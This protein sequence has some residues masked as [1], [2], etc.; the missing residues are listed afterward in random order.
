MRILVTGGTGFVGAHL[1]RFL[2]SQDSQI[3]VLASGNR[4]IPNVPGVQYREADI[5]DAERV[6]SIVREVNPEQIYHL[7]GITAVDLSWAQPRLTYE[8]N[9]FGA[10]NLFEAAM[11][12]PAPPRIL[13]IST[14]QVYASSSGSLS[15][16][17]P[18]RPNNPYAASK[19]MAELLIAQYQDHASGGI[20]TARPFNHTGP[21][22]SP[23]FVLPSMAK[24]FAE[25]E[26]GLR[27]PHL[28]LGNVDVGRDFTDVRDIVRAYGMLLQKGKASE[29]YNV[30][31]GSAVLLSDIIKVFQAVSGTEV[32]IEIDPEKVRPKDAAEICGDPHKLQAATS[33]DREIPLKKTVEDTLNYWRSQCRRRDSI[34]P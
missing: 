33:W 32:T 16:D 19:A 27:P 13:N 22:Q 14:S 31:S 12:L 20:I 34:E 6:R 26:S 11:N 1:I 5:R 30:C 15:E 29:V 17:S 28:K 25:I 9:V 18:L 8:V 3:F 4:H 23:N 2:K 24:Q 7:A 10:Q 21:G